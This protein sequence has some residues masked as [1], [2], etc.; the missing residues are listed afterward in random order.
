VFALVFV[1]YSITDCF[2]PATSAF[3]NYLPRFLTRLSRCG[4]CSFSSSIW[5]PRH[6]RGFLEPVSCVF[7]PAGLF[8]LPSICNPN[9]GILNIPHSLAV[10][11]MFQYAPARVL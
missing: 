6:C 8:F 2:L 10:S 1:Y 3:Y 9:F 11:G 4:T 5:W 7:I